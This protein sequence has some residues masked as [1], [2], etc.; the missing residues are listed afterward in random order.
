VRLNSADSV[1][2]V[3]IDPRGARIASIRML[4]P[5]VELLMTTPWAG[6][7]WDGSP[8]WANSSAE[9][10]RRY[11]GGW[12]V[13]TPHAGDARIVDGIEHPFHGEA[14]WRLWRCVHA[15]T[16]TCTWEVV[17]RTV[18][19]V[20]RRTVRLTADG[21]EIVQ[22]FENRSAHPVSFSWTEHPAFGESLISEATTVEVG[23]RMVPAAFPEKGA[24]LS[25]FAEHE[26]HG[27]GRFRIHNPPTG[28][29]VAM[30]W[31]ASLLP[32]AVVWQEHAASTGFPWWEQ[33][34]TFAVEPASRPYEPD[35]GSLGPLTV[36]P[37]DTRVSVLGLTA[38]RR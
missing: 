21:L 15:T 2:T 30:Q 36:G 25:A 9:W 34:N 3:V 22:E 35:A 18:P 14:A 23:D 1:L 26:V 11:P 8:G 27:V 6:E 32:H 24:A 10:H 13:L 12:H 17:L 38:R 37:R 7:D 33:V 4:E 19:L 16:T 5:D 28:L 31:D 20:L 29:E